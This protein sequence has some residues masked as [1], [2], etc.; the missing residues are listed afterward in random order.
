PAKQMTISSDCNGSMPAFD[1]QGR[2]I[3]LEVATNKALL[4]DW[5]TLARAGY[6]D[7]A[8]ALALVTSNVARVLGVDERKGSLAA[9]MDAD[10]TMLGAD[11]N[12]VAVFARG[13]RVL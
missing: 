6:L 2:L 7:F 9:G 4:G 10:I 13:Q 11:L 12:P 1:D 3:A 5:Q 8:E